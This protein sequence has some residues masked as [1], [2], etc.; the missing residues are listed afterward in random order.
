MTIDKTDHTANRNRCKRDILTVIPILLVIIFAGICS[1]CWFQLMLIQG[2]SML[3]TYHHLQLVLLDKRGNEY[4]QG[5]VIAFQCDELS[6]V[7]VKRIIAGPGDETVIRG[8]TLFVNGNVSESFSEEGIFAYAGL[9][10]QAITLTD[11]QYLVIGDNI[12]ESKDSRYPEVG[13]VDDRD[14]IGRII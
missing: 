9:L 1:R 13:I 2:D 3:P 12:S 8:G 5:D 7:L 11:E 6:S 14:I 4:E 10:S